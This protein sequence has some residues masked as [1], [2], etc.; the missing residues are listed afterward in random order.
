MK[1][2]AMLCKTTQDGQVI[3]KSSGK[4]WFPG[5]R[6]GKRL[7]YSFLENPINSMKMQK[8]MEDES[9]RSE[10]VQYAIGEV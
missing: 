7:Q 1:L 5:A 2:W 10:G 9:P 6:N 4:T 3:V 8:Y